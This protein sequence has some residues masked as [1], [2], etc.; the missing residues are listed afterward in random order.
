[1][2]FLH[3]PTFPHQVELHIG[4][5]KLNCSG[6]VLA[7]QSSVLERKFRE[8]KGVLLFEEFIDVDGSCTSLYRCIEYLHGAVLEIDLETLDVTLKFASFYEV[9]DLF[10]EAVHWLSK[11][12]DASKSV[13]SAVHFLKIASD[14][15]L[16]H[17]LR[18]E[19]VVS[20]FIQSNSYLFEHDHD[21]I[22][23]GGITGPVMILLCKQIPASIGGLLI[24]WVALSNCNKDFIIKSGLDDIDFSKVFSKAEDFASFVDTLSSAPLSNNSFRTLLN[25]QRSFFIPQSNSGNKSDSTNQVQASKSSSVQDPTTNK[26]FHGLTL[27]PQAI[28]GITRVLMPP[29]TSYN[30]KLW[31][32][33]VL[34]LNNDQILIGNLPPYAEETRLKRIIKHGPVR[35]I[36]ISFSLG[37]PRHHYAV[38]TFEKSE[39][40]FYLWHARIKHQNMFCYDSYK[41]DILCHPD[42]HELGILAWREAHFLR[43]NITRT[44]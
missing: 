5:E 7:Q 15:N 25:L 32:D 27:S 39:T 22:I 34:Q 44:S 35:N 23:E 42:L 4:D 40:A 11:Y 19:K 33:Q 21:D 31:W 24:K 1:M 2:R 41:L 8:D 14:L 43:R 30:S 29:R 10:E 37:S 20:Q 9:K 17:C 6:A 38:M 26:N 3:D 16:P 13:R 12:L 28:A 18:I 36:V